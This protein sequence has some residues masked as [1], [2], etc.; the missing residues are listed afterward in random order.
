MSAAPALGSRSR[1][2]ILRQTT[3][4]LYLDG[5]PLGEILLP[6][7][8]VPA[9]LGRDLD[10]FIYRDSED[11]L[12]ATT[13]TPLAMPGEFA[14][15]RIQEV[16]PS[17][18]AFLDWGLAKDLLLP[19]REQVTF[20]REGALVVV[21][22]FIDEKSDRIVASERIDRWLNLT[23]PEYAKDQEMKVLVARE[24]PLGYSA[25][26]ENAHVGLL[27]RTDLANPLRIGETLTA[28]VRA[29][30][31]DGKIDLAL[32]RAGF[33]RVKPL[34]EQILEAIRTAGGRLA[35]HDGS[36]PAEIRDALG[37]SKKAFKQ[38]VGVLY[39]KKLLVIEAD[40]IRL[41]GPAGPQR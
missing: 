23:P 22:V 33:S 21:R 25:I 5:G 37:V 6:R 17:L 19:R 39:R 1:L 18:G 13:E 31:P 16:K 10:V 40:G 14:C 27:Y 32:D 35:L 24:T 38:A 11:R 12:V 3:P 36:T 26:I 28:F 34:A 4:G 7:R 9:D 15:L 41:G 29:I 20:S 30:R 8:Y 2:E